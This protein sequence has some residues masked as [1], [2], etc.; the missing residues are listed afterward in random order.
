MLVRRIASSLLLLALPL[1]AAA[2]PSGRV[3]IAQGVDPTSLDTMNQQE[4]PASNL[5]RH[6][7]EGLVMRD[8]N[9][10]LVPALAV[11]LPKTVAPTT[12]EVKLRRGVRFHNGEEFTAES[13]K[14]SLERLANPANKLR[15]TPNF[16]PIDRVEIVDPHTV[17][18]HTRK[19]WPIFAKAMAFAQAAMYPPKAYEGK[20]STYISKNPIGTGPYR[21]VRWAKDEEIVLEANE[22]YWRGA[23]KIKTVVFRPIPDDAVRVAALQNGEI[24]LAVNI[25]PH[26]A[27]VIDRHPRVTLSTAPSVRTIQLLYYTH[28]MDAQH[29]VVGPYAGPTVDRRVRRAMNVAVDVDELIRTVLDGKGVRV[30][31][32]LTDRHFGFDR[33]LKPLRPDPAQAARLL[34]E[35]GHPNGIDIVLNSPQGRYVRDKEVAEAVSGQ[36]TR[37]GIRTTPRT[38]EWGNYLNSMAYVHKAGPV[39]LIG[40]GAGTYDAESIYVPLFRTGGIFVNYHNPEFDRLVDEAQGTMDEKKRLELYHRINRLWVEE[41]AAMPLYQQVDLYGVNRRLVWKARGDEVIKASDMAFKDD[42]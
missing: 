3:V 19:P 21:Y 31:T 20:D 5:A 17:R 8:Q 22:Q 29:K 24:D 26:L 25:P 32:M 10:D 40:W 12:W 35:A 9:L 36:L 2:A 11:E 41:A 34:A 15:A 14:F 4:T 27:P 16:V 23:P 37:A 30:A 42:R 18:V 13:V 7:Y 1:T 6:L 39:W 28:Q 33:E 38:Y